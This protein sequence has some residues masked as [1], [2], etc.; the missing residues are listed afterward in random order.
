MK[1]AT[2]HTKELEKFG[3]MIEK[4]INY[5]DLTPDK[6]VIISLTEEGHRSIL[7]PERIKLLLTIKHKRPKNVGELAEMVGRRK[8]AVSRDLNILK[9]YG[10]LEL[11]QHGKEKRPIVEKEAIM[12]S[13]R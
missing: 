2:Q 3:E 11:I 4:A 8:D 7:T 13:L 10:F 12:M 6:L 5:P 1:L 9:N